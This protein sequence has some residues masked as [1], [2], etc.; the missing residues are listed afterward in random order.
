MPGDVL[1]TSTGTM[2]F[3]VDEFVSVLRSGTEKT[4]LRVVRSR[5]D[6]QNV[7]YVGPAYLRRVLRNA[8]VI[9]RSRRSKFNLRNAPR[10]PHTEDH[11][12]LDA[13]FSTRPVGRQDL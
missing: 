6:R 8:T 9:K 1:K 12:A 4:G 11:A 3:V 13:A 7:A 10:V 2:W 5:G